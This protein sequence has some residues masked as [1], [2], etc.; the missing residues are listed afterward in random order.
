MSRL[1]D[2]TSGHTHTH[3]HMDQEDR[4]HQKSESHN[5]LY[6]KD[7]SDTIN[8]FLLGRHKITLESMNES[9]LLFLQSSSSLLLF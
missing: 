8:A 6:R 1:E 5:S 9:F 4:G 3:V 7:I 2:S